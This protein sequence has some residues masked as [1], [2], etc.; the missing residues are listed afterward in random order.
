MTSASHGVHRNETTNQE[1]KQMKNTI[2]IALASIGLFLSIGAFSGPAKAALSN[3]CA[4][5]IISLDFNG[6]PSPPRMRIFCSADGNNYY[7]NPNSSCPA[8]SI[9]QVKMWQT[10]A[11][12]AFLSGKKLNIGYT[13]CGVDRSIQSLEM[14]N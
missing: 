6:L 9:D 11:N 2:K 5:T 8:A 12:S 1:I 14:T 3:N 13:S 4:P 7:T 10:I